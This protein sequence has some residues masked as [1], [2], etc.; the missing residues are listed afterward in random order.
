MVVRASGFRWH[1]QFN[2]AVSANVLR[3]LDEVVY[4]N[5]VKTETTI[6]LGRKGVQQD[7][8]GALNRLTR[9]TNETFEELIHI[10]CYIL[11]WE[12]SNIGHSPWKRPQL[13]AM[14]RK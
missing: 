13:F 9:D 1:G 7:A 12:V 14:K 4:S 2:Q 8:L 10:S 3:Q 11:S 6:E 5:S